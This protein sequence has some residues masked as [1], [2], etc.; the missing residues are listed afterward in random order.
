MGTENLLI[1]FMGLTVLQEYLEN[2]VHL[3]GRGGDGMED[4]STPTGSP[5]TE[6]CAHTQT[7]RHTSRVS[8]PCTG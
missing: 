2:W 3:S 1:Q 4:P 7:A 8:T 6:G 5:G